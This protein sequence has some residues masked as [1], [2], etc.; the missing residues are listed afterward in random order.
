MFNLALFAIALQILYVNGVTHTLMGELTMNKNVRL[1]FSILLAVGVMVGR[2]F[3]ARR[4]YAFID[5]QHF[6]SLGS[7]LVTI[8]LVLFIPGMILMA[9][10][11]WVFSPRPI[12]GTFRWWAFLLFVIF[13]A[14]SA[15]ITRYNITLASLPPLFGRLDFPP[16]GVP[17]FIAGVALVGS[18]LR[19]ES[20]L[21]L[22]R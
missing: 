12:R 17:Q 14:F 21:S 1:T 10:V 6:T 11:F 13:G 19:G 20:H 8:S 2:F 22:R 15:Y 5:A 16:F 9:L 4:F 7:L 18:F 3:L